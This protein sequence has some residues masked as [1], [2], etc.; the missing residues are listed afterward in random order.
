MR[1]VAL[2]LLSGV[3]L[4]LLSGARG[5]EYTHEYTVS[6]GNLIFR[7]QIDDTQIHVALDEPGGSGGWVAIGV[8][9]SKGCRVH[10]RT[11]TH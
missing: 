8:F 4:L 7:W 5:V 11:R 9:K 1:T 3:A 10:P 6:E 2:L